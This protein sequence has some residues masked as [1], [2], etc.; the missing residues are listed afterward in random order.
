MFLPVFAEF[1]VTIVTTTE[2]IVIVFG[3]DL[4]NGRQ[5]LPNSSVSFL[6]SNLMRLGLRRRV[7]GN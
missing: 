4:I 2:W 6:L 3:N 1:I 7:P 5:H